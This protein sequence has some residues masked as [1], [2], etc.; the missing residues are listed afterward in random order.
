MR[1]T[2]IGA[3]SIPIVSPGVVDLWD[4]HWQGWN[5]SKEKGERD[6]NLDYLPTGRGLAVAQWEFQR[7]K[8]VEV[9]EDEVVDGGG[10][11]DVLHR[12]HD[13]AHDG[14]KGPPADKQSVFSTL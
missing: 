11:Q 7:E 4:P 5:E 1:I 9:D 2:T 14:A 10:D 6:T 12:A 3:S 8:T 13:V